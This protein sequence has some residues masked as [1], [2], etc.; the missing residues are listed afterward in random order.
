MQVTQDHKHAARLVALMLAMKACLAEAD[1]ET[2]ARAGIAVGDA[3][4][5]DDPLAIELGRF[6]DMFQ[7]ARRDEKLL[8]SAG[9]QLWRAVERSTWPTPADRADIEG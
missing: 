6:A 5:H 7:R 8:R 1:A 3:F 9:Q 4:P 2:L